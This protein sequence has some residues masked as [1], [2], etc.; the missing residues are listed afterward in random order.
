MVTLVAVEAIMKASNH[1]LEFS[2]AESFKIEGL[3]KTLMLNRRSHDQ[4]ADW[5]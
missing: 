2:L 3:K 4:L 5:H 1:R